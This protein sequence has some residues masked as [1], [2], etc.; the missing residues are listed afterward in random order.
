VSVIKILIA[1][2]HTILRQG[3]VGILEGYPDLCVVAEAENGLSMVSK[4]FAFQ[5]DV[6]LSDIEM[7]EMNG[8]EAAREI[9][10]KDP[11][12]KILF[13]SMHNS[14]ENI[15]RLLLVKAYGL[16]SKEVIKNELVLAIR[17]VADGKTYFQ[18]K[19]EEEINNIRLKYSSKQKRSFE[20]DALLLTPSE[21]KILLYIAEGKTSQE[22]AAITSKAKRTVDSVRATI[23]AKLNLHSLPQLIKYAIDY[24]FSFKQKKEE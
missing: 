6:V 1:D 9:L 22:I 4:Y 23:M 15:Y 3:L 14:D 12:A 7:P 13:L 17:T 8:V 18:G 2:D 19:S 21:K 20:E 24:S 16:I 10:L 5:P 11:G